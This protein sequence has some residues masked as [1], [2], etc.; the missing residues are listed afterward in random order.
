MRRVYDDGRGLE[1]FYGSD[2]W[3]VCPACSR[4]AVHRPVR[5][6]WRLICEACGYTTDGADFRAGRSWR[7][8]RTPREDR[9]GLELWLHTRCAGHELCVL[10]PAHLEWLERWVAADLR[11]REGG[12]WANNRAATSRMPR[13]IKSRANR[14]Q[15]LRAL[16]R[17]RARALRT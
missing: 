15:V 16:A 7:A 10:G 5:G 4:R 9:F 6:G 14:P 2:V 11:E 12:Q 3:V 8:P 13:W 1:S 17:L